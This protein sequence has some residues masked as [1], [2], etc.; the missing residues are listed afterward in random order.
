M[1]LER[2]VCVGATQD[3]KTAGH[4]ALMVAWAASAR[5]PDGARFVGIAP[6]ASV[7]VYAIPRPDV[8]VVSL[9]L[10]IARAASGLT[11]LCLRRAR[12]WWVQLMARPTVTAAPSSAR[13]E[14]SGTAVGETVSTDEIP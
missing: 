11:S 8:D 13:V 12:R 2:R 4:A 1:E 7:R 5:R 6:D 9:P 14:G 10:A 3:P